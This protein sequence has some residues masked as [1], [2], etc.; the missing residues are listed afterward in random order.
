MP[1][2]LPGGVL[3]QGSRIL[4]DGVRLEGA[5]VLIGA[6]RQPARVV[7]AEPQRLEAIVPDDAPTGESTLQLRRGSELSR[8]FP[9]RIAREQIGLYSRNGAG[10]GPGK[11]RNADGAENS[12]AR[13]ARPG[14]RVSVALTGAGTRPPLV[15]VGGVQA[16]AVSLK[17]RPPD[18]EL[19]V[20]LPDRSP[21][22]C[23]VPLY[24][25]HPGGLPSNVVT[26]AIRRGAGGGPCQMPASS[27]VPLVTGTEANIAVLTRLDQLTLSGDHRWIEEEGL[28]AFV[29]RKPEPAITPFLLAPPA[30]TCTVYTGSAQSPF[31]IPTAIGPGLLSELG[32]SGLDA[33]PVVTLRR[34]GEERLLPRTPGGSGYY[35][36][37][38]GVE[39]SRRWPLFLEPG[40]IYVAA[41]RFRA[42]A[43][44]PRA[45]EWLDRDRFAVVDRGRPLTVHWQLPKKTLPPFVFLVAANTDPVTTSRA[46]AY[47]V[48]DAR[49]GN[50][51][52]PAAAFAN[53][54][55]G[56]EQGPLSSQLGLATV[57][58]NSAEPSGMVFV[59][60]V[61]ARAVTYR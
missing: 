24:A 38:L 55:G 26:V 8:P 4:I 58:L 56:A 25:I 37:K 22:G 14:E 46:M 47:C 32:D 16:A 5:E 19:L 9:I 3:A 59:I 52:M 50:F 34:G 23:W 27:P 15:F 39:D 41:Q 60:Y 36:A 28:A 48:A 61:S 17:S 11:I 21:E 12:V 6:R 57:E 29:K 35:H 13:P 40:T 44:G 53:F 43:A 49:T 7:R 2:T 45:L 31:T 20:T 10:W 54:P 51:T 30:G 33:G 1:P 42:S 18:G